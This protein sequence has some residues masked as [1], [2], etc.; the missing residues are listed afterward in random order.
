M[1]TSICGF[2]GQQVKFVTSICDLERTID[3]GGPPNLRGNAHFTFRGRRLSA[4]LGEQVTT[5]CLRRFAFCVAYNVGRQSEAQFEVRPKPRRRSAEVREAIQRARV[6]RRRNAARALVSARS[7]HHP[8][9]SDTS[10]KPRRS[11]AGTP[12]ADSRCGHHGCSRSCFLIASEGLLGRLAP[13][14]LP[15]IDFPD[16]RSDNGCSVGGVVKFQPH[17]AT[18]EADL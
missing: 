16:G 15:F 12:G 13:A 3:A 4:N 9:G 18:D 1:S 2:P 17:S 6:V 10:S 8:R 7:R 14:G 5:P 11:R